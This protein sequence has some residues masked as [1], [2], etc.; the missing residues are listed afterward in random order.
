MVDIILKVR[1]IVKRFGGLLA[2]NNVDLDLRPG[3]VLCLLGDNG[4]GKSTL[5]K[6]ISGVYK[7]DQGEIYWQGEKVKVNSPADMLKYGLETIYQDLSLCGN[8]DVPANIFLGREKG[9]MKYGFIK[10]LDN[11]YMY[12]ESRKVLDNLDIEVPKLNI[13]VSKLSGGQQQAVATSRS[14]YWDAKVLIMDEPT[15]GLAVAEQQ[16]VLGLVNRL[17]A[18]GIAIIY[19]THQMRDVFLVADRIM[20]LRRGENVGE[21]LVDETSPEEIVG[22]I[23][24]ADTVNEPDHE[25]KNY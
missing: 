5:I 2:V 20:V 17:K 19:I 8:L 23:T 1:N 16:K 18:D 7:C 13:H 10:V 25:F 12:K 14:I 15:A 21:R 9:K 22:L 6:C 4:A 11:D 3:E 24:G